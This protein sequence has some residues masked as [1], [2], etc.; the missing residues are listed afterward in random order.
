MKKSAKIITIVLV[1]LL[2]LVWAAWPRLSMHGPV[3]DEP[4]RNAERRAALFASKEH[5][6][7]E[8]KAAYDAEVDLLDKHMEMRAVTILIVG[9]AF[10][11]AG[12]YLFWRYAPKKTTA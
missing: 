9:L 7:P 2:E 12:I 6:T 5:P 3:L 1:L 4:Y 11:A 8:T 10:N